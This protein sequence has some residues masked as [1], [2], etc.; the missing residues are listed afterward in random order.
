[1]NE[2]VTV[3]IVIRMVLFIFQTAN[4]IFRHQIDPAINNDFFVKS[5]PRKSQVKDQNNCKI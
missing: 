5:S 2:T 4:A 3:K 1:M